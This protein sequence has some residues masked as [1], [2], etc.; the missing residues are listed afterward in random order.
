MNNTL[1][2]F[3]WYQARKIFWPLSHTKDQINTLESAYCIYP[4]L[5]QSPEEYFSIRKTKNCFK[6]SGLLSCT[7]KLDNTVV[8]VIKM[9]IT[10][11]QTEM[12]VCP[13]E[14]GMKAFMMYIL[15]GLCKQGHII[16]RRKIKKLQWWTLM[17]T[18]S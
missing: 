10:L 14:V 17:L 1:R 7:F 9:K 6:I 13:V 15:S 3:Y 2:F 11:L 4:N 5:R 16:R 18:W 8:F 12:H